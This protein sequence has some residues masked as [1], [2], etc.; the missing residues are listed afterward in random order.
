MDSYQ[1]HGTMRLPGR[2]TS[3]HQKLSGLGEQSYS[4]LSWECPWKLVANVPKSSEA[5]KSPEPTSGGAS[6]SRSLEADPSLCLL[7]KFWR[8]SLASDPE[9]SWIS[10]RQAL[11]GPFYP[12]P[13][14]RSHHPSAWTSRLVAEDQNAWAH[15]G[16]GIWL[17][18]WGCSDPVGSF[19]GRLAWSM[20]LRQLGCGDFEVADIKV[21]VFS[22]ATQLWALQQPPQPLTS[23][24]SPPQLGH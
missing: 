23:Q 21:F 10:S 15:T 8:E 18:G 13:D 24:P 5:A 1:Q 16:E 7:R 9:R 12:D 11:T 14:E 20:P 22:A 17:L 19:K 6:G 3:Y 2:K 4:G